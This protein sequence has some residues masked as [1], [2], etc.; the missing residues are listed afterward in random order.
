MRIHYHRSKSEGLIKY[1]IIKKCF[2]FSSL[3][4]SPFVVLGNVNF[5]YIKIEKMFVEIFF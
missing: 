4:V 2:F 5:P 3:S 1:K